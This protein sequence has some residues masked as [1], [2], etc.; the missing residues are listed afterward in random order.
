LIPRR[1]RR[2][3]EVLLLAG[4]IF[5]LHG[6]QTRDVVRGP[7]PAFEVRLLDGSVVKL[8]DYRGR[9]LLLQFWATWCPV[10]RLETGS[11]EAIARDHQVL[12]I[13]LDDMSAAE[14]ERWMEQ[15][16]LSYPVALDGNGQLARRYGVKGVPSIIIVDAEGNIRFVE[17]GYT[18]QAGLRI[19]LWWAG[20]RA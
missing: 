3:L 19:R 13:A 16:G 15:E 18:T 1:W 9:P 2:P 7:A 14:L 8:R 17:V 4:V 10:C 20:W 11:I 6:Y 5:G 12:T